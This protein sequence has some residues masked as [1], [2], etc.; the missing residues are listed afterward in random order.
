MKRIT[1]L[2]AEAPLPER[3]CV[4]RRAESVAATP[5]RATRW[6]HC[7][8]RSFRRCCGWSRATKHRPGRGCFLRWAGSAAATPQRATRW[9][10]A[11]GRIFALPPERRLQAAA[12]W[13]IMLLPRERSVPFTMQPRSGERGCVPR[14]AGS[15]AATR[16]RATRWETSQPPVISTLLRLVED[17]TA[18]LRGKRLDIFR[19]PACGLVPPTSMKKCFE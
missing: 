10:T 9:E 11:Q 14:R 5:Q 13:Q 8:H 2:L 3:G 4:P 18:A 17:D 7:D 12:T 6:E 16:L 19:R 1:V 15:A